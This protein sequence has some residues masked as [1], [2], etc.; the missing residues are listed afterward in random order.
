MHR[1]REATL[2]TVSLQS[3]SGLQEAMGKRDRNSFGQYSLTCLVD[4]GTEGS[5]TEGRQI[6][7]LV[8]ENWDPTSC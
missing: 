6:L 5:Q 8:N 1:F 2:L 4:R 3:V 7:V